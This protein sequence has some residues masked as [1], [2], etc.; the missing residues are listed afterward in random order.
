MPIPRTDTSLPPTR[1]AESWMAKDH[2]R[3]GDL[4]LEDKIITQEQLDKAVTEQRRGGQLLGATLLR[5]GLVTEDAL[6]QSLHRQLGLS[7]IDLN[8]VSIDD[9]A[10][11]C[12]KEDVA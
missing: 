7:L 12:V 11:A 4:L 3:L 1:N 5:L 9:Q 8:E 10:L 6:M 2:K